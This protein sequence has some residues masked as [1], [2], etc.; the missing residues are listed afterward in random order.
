MHTYLAKKT[1][2]FRK[3]THETHIDDQKNVMKILW[4]IS[5]GG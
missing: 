5:S 3:S 2:A 1:Y 4:G